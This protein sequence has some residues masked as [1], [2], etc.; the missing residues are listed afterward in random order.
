M[1]KNIQ[2]KNVFPCGILYD[3]QLKSFLCFVVFVFSIR[4][5]ISLWPEEKPEAQSIHL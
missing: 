4:T 1:S 5:V 2:F 3:D